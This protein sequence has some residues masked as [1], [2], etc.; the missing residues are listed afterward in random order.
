MIKENSLKKSSFDIFDLWN[1][2]A[3]LYVLK[4]K[5]LRVVK[6]GKL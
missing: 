4:S 6:T 5:L 1:V 3:V 2:S